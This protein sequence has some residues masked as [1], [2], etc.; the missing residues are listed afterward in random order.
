[1]KRFSRLRYNLASQLHLPISYPMMNDIG[2]SL[3]HCHY[4]A[5]KLENMHTLG[6]SNNDSGVDIIQDFPS[7][8]ATASTWK[9]WDPLLPKHKH[10][11]CVCFFST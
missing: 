5:H 9:H 10:E 8:Y 2:G 11:V 4:H 7:V 6:N 1:M 3:P